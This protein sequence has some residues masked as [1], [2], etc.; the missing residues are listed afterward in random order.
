VFNRRSFLATLGSLSA[1]G[2]TTRTAR[3]CHRRSS[4]CP[5][6]ILKQPPWIYS[7]TTG[8]VV[9][10]NSP[11]QTIQASILLTFGD[12]IYQRGWY[13]VS[14]RQQL[15]LDGGEFMRRRTW[16]AIW[17]PSKGA[18]APA[19]SFEMDGRDSNG[20]VTHFHCVSGPAYFPPEA[21]DFAF[22]NASIASG[23]YSGSGWEAYRNYLVSSQGLHPQWIPAFGVF[24]QNDSGTAWQRGGVA[25]PGQ[26]HTLMLEF[27]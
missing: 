17:N 4:C 6:G 19:Q 27:N 15:Q 14:P 21:H 22:T 8:I 25:Y 16:F 12:T 2:V 7:I 23:L 3:A 24:P 1:L 9:Y 5:T 11:D 26:E 20:R 13:T 10:N 18:Y